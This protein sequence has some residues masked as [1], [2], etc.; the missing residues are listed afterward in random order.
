MSTEQIRRLIAAHA[1]RAD[2]GVPGVMIKKVS[3]PTEPTPSMAEPI[4]AFPFQG[5]KRIALGDRVYDQAPGTYMVVAVDLP[6]TGHYTVASRVEPY[7]GFALELEPAAIAELLVGE[8][9]GLRR[10][11]AP[12]PSG[13]SLHEASREIID[14]VTRLLCL[15]D[16]PSDAPVLAPLIEREI[17]WRV[18]TGPAGPAVRQIGLRDSSLTHVEVGD[19]GGLQLE[20]EAEVGLDT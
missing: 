16:R 10:V 20:G 14:A 19:R 8:A 5:A 11:H 3:D 17:L 9:A 18:L 15:I 2:V 7:L 12:P 6:I 1:D 13:I 4:V